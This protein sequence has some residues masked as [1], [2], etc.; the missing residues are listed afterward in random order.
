MAA[1]V[2]GAYFLPVFVT[3]RDYIKDDEKGTIF[4]PLDFSIPVDVLSLGARIA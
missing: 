4:D 3:M 2:S 1:I